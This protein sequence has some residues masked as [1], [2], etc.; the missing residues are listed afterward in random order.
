MILWDL[1]EH[2]AKLASAGSAGQAAGG[3]KESKAGASAA[4]PYIAVSAIE[5]GHRSSITDLVWIPEQYEVRCACV[6]VRLLLGR[7]VIYRSCQYEAVSPNVLLACRACVPLPGYPFNFPTTLHVCEEERA[8]ERERSL[9]TTGTDVLSLGI[10]TVR[11]VAFF[12]PQS[13]AWTLVAQLFKAGRVGESTTRQSVQFLTVAADSS[14]LVWD[15]RIEGKSGRGALR[16]LDLTWRPFLRV[17]CHCGGSCRC[18]CWFFM[19]C[20]LLPMSLFAV[21]VRNIHWSLY[22][23]SCPC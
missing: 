6:P 19:S 5:H 16:E 4:V 7:F 11:L 8:R 20:W 22:Q 9:I 15:T 23:W 17:R 2:A 21:V 3:A 10:L 14:A 13:S 1:S 18:P 12:H